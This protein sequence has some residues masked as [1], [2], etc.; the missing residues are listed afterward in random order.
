M[1][2]DNP[3]PKGHVY[4]VECE[5]G[6]RMASNLIAMA[7][8]LVTSC[9]GLVAMTSN[10]VAVASKKNLRR[11]NDNLMPESSSESFCSDGTLSW[12]HSQSLKL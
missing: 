10:L 4:L 5:T 2:L 1:K 3:V 6:I 9:D 8:N 12:G 7:S 11:C